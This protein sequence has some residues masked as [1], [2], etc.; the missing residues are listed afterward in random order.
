MA[1]YATRQE[2]AILKHIA[3]VIDDKVDHLVINRQMPNDDVHHHRGYIAAYKDLAVFITKE[4]RKK[5]N[6]E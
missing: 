3:E 5:I 2:D 4:L 1:D 6:E